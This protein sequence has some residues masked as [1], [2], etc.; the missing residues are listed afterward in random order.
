[1]A[2]ARDAAAEVSFTAAPS[3]GSA[4]T[5][6]TVTASPGGATASGASSPITVSGLTN[7]TA[8]TF[9]VTATNANGT[10]AESSAS[11]AIT[12]RANVRPEVSGSLTPSGVTE[13]GQT[14][15]SASTFSGNP[16]PTYTYQWKACNG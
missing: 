15:T 6:Y 9:T 4:I 5:T 2:S 10:G 1:V 8:Y 13:V 16:T 7:G 11:T 3:G 14:L 12:P